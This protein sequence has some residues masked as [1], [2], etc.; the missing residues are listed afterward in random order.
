MLHCFIGTYIVC[1]Q[2][3]YHRIKQSYCYIEMVIIS[4][5]IVSVY[6]LI[7][8]LGVNNRLQGSSHR[9]HTQVIQTE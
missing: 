4:L 7:V 3:S 2:L 6:S 1:V 5:S 9:S 8:F